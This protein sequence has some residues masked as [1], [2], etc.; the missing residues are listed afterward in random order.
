MMVIV[1]R[2]GLIGVAFAIGLVVG[3]SAVPASRAA[4]ADLP[5]WKGGVSLYRN[6]SFTTQ[7]SWL[8]CTA[9]GVQI[10]RNIV[11]HKADHSTGG[12]RR[13]FNWMRERNRYDLPLSAGVD[14]AGWTAGLRHFVDDRYRL[15]ASRT[16]DA[17]LRSAVTRMR[18]TGLPVALTVSHGNHG[19]ILTGFRATADPAKTSSFKVTSVRVTGPLYGLQSKNGYDMPPNTKLTTAQLKR[20]FTPW[21]YAPK[22][23]VWDGRYV[24][25]EPVPATA[26]T[27]AKAKAPPS[28]EALPPA[29]APPP[30]NP[31]LVPLGSPV[32]GAADLREVESADP[33]VSASASEMDEQIAV[34]GL[35]GARPSTA[36]AVGEPEVQPS[37]GS[38][39]SAAVAVSVVVIAPPRR[40][41]RGGAR[42]W[43]H[44]SA[45]SAADERLVMTAGRPSGPLV[46][47]AVPTDIRWVEDLLVSVGADRVAR[48][49]EL[50]S[51][52]DHPML[53][54]TVDG[55]GAGLLT[56]VIRG[57]ACEILTLHAVERWHGAGSALL[58]AVER[59]AAQT[60]CTSLWVV[61]TNDNT[62][63]LRFYQRRELQSVPFT[64]ALST[65]RAS[66]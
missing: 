47:P 63:A 50:L 35:V 16:F 4:A 61:T 58:S 51:A 55:A 57:A 26:K 48:A 32:I 64:S 2:R 28:A 12:Q 21:R 60:G 52:L 41:R 9:A 20:F 18:R 5:A 45:V 29:E 44:T 10:A 6:G 31:G 33:V 11:E 66:A 38:A 39:S 42:R 53:V 49:G 40:P 23:M 25:I 36:P 7:R 34:A 14:P 46:R 59:V 22:R 56:Y 65:M 13:Y 27:A 37:A 1:V 15:V 24:S 19:W 62:D 30:S 17:A 8:W 3:A 54:A 43:A